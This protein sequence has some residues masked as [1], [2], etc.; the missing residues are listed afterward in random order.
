MAQKLQH[1]TCFDQTK[2]NVIFSEKQLCNKIKKK[3]ESKGKIKQVLQHFGRTDAV[4][5]QLKSHTHVR[6][7]QDVQ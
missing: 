7:D 3:Q 1:I 4:I 2:I 5:V 6:A